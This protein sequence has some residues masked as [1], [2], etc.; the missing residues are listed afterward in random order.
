[1]SISSDFLL[2]TTADSDMVTND[3]LQELINALSNGTIADHLRGA[4]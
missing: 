2:V 4:V 3:S 1:M